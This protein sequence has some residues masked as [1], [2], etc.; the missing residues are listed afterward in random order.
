MAT[1]PR[2]LLA[3]TVLALIVLVALGAF[4]APAARATAGAP[5]SAPPLTPPKAWIL[6][7]AT[8]GIVLDAGNDRTPLPPASLTKLLT[9]VIAAQTLL[10]T[11]GVPVSARA[12]GEPAR[13]IG[14][15]QGEVWPFRDALYALLLS[16]ANDAAAAIGER[17][18][19]S[20]ENFAAMMADAGHHLGL[21]DNPVLQD[22]AGLDDNFSVAGGNMI[23]ARDIAILAR[24]A[25]A[26]PLVAAAM[27]TPIYRFTGPDG[28]HHRLTNHIYSFLTTYPGAI[29]LKPGYTQKAGYG[30]ALAAERNGRTLIAVVLDAPNPTANATALLDHGFALAAGAAGTGDVLPTVQLAAGPAAA[31]SGTNA[32]SSAAPAP[33]A[34]PSAAAPAKQRRGAGFASP[35]AMTIVAILVLI[36]AGIA[37]AARRR[38]VRRRRQRRSALRRAVAEGRVTPLH[39]RARATIQA[40]TAAEDWPDE[41]L[42]RG[43][44]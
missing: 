34:R 44:R 20:L 40:G 9:A 38:V 11:D 17:I 8:S 6:A 18:G 33:L 21:A 41:R 4:A 28:F 29:G 19:G 10:P 7:D 43:R 26:Q 24:A 27:R 12:A 15:K 35:T 42:G 13:K 16:S 2:T 39:Q 14:M 25:L 36:P 5:A 31:P 32:A 37:V 3:S 30:I 1:F 22:P 23:S